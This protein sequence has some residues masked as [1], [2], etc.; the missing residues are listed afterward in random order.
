MLLCL[1][2]LI[3]IYAD[4][5]EIKIGLII[6]RIKP[7]NLFEIGFSFLEVLTPVQD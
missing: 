3:E 4:F 1:P 6:I 2:E 7:D 5:S